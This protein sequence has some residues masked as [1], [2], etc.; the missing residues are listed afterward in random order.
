MEFPAG[1]HR[2][3]IR[4]GPTKDNKEEIADGET[5][6]KA[7]EESRRNESFVDCDCLFQGL[8][9]LQGHGFLLRQTH[10]HRDRERETSRQFW[11]EIFLN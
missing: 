11:I 1:P 2:L 3:T 7:C 10:T 5:Q 8:A 9:K 4:G 6:S